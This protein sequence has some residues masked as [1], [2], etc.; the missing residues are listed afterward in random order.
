MYRIKLLP[1][2]EEDV[3]RLNRQAPSNIKKLTKLIK[4]LQE[5]PRMRNRQVKRLKHYKEETWSRRL[6][7]EHRLI[8][9]I[10][11]EIVEVLVLS[12]FGHYNDK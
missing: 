2:A 1:Q 11:D 12:T 6:S 5:H 9:R 3:K 4:E 8:Y 10:Y 7:G